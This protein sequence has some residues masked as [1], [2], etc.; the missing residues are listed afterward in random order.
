MWFK[1]ITTHGFLGV[2]LVVVVVFLEKQTLQ[3]MGRDLGQ[4]I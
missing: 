2:F 4:T 1:R 3:V